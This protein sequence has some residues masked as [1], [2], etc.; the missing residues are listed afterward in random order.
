MLLSW[1]DP[2]AALD[3]LA[4]LPKLDHLSAVLLEAEESA[5]GEVQECYFDAVSF[6]EGEQPLSGSASCH[7]GLWFTPSESILSAEQVEILNTH[8]GDYSQEVLALASQLQQLGSQLS[9]KIMGALQST[10]D[11]PGIEITEIASVSCRFIRDHQQAVDH[12]TQLISNAFSVSRAEV[13][14][15]LHLGSVLLNGSSLHEGQVVE[16]GDE[17]QIGRNFKRVI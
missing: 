4:A 5:G 13:R 7:V 12:N 8:L 14:R 15:H 10:G 3:E 2:E 17:V 11:Q 9:H 16:P 6:A 1:L